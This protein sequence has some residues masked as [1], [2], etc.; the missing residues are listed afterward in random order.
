M[1]LAVRAGE[2]EVV[3]ELLRAAS[4]GKKQPH[5]VVNAT[6]K[7]GAGVLHYAVAGPPASAPAIVSL[8]LSL[9]GVAVN[10]PNRRGETP[11]HVAAAAGA[12]RALL[13]SLL[14]AGADGNA[15][16]SKGATPAATA[17]RAGEGDLVRLLLNPSLVDL[18][19]DGGD[20]EREREREKEKEREREREREREKVGGLSVSSSPTRATSSPV[21]ELS[22]RSSK[23]RS[24][25]ERTEDELSALKS[26]LHAAAE[27]K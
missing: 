14:R 3:R 25:A 23:R 15:V 10:S 8:L 13:A 4:S 26:L 20:S 18:V 2:V 21:R 22:T 9:D 5:R 7:R 1:H 27:T 12:P 19:V 17:E 16:D 24:S 11:L 6:T